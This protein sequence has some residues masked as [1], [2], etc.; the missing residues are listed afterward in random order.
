MP[1]KNHEDLSFE[2]AMEKLE[3][4]VEKLEEGEV[5]LEKA[6]D[7]FQEGMELS[8]ICSDKLENVQEKMAEILTEEQTLE[9]FNIEED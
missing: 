5:P 1:K 4:I 9:S 6:I 7:Y 8:K 3:R 2:E